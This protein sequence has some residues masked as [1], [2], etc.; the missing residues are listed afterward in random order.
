MIN[1]NIPQK[2]DVGLMGRSKQM[3]HLYARSGLLLGGVS[4]VGRPE[5]VM[6]PGV[7]SQ[8]VAEAFGR[9]LLD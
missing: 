6:L 4:V 7:A 2:A 5:R 1:Q 9:G 3:G 8:S